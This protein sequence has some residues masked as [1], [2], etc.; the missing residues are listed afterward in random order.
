MEPLSKAIALN[1]RDPNLSSYASGLATSHILQRDYKKAASWARV[2]MRQPSSHFIA[3]MHL[4]AALALLGDRQGA[5]KARTKLLVLKPDFSLD[6]VIRNWP[7]KQ[8]SDTAL[9][10]R[11]LRSAG[12]LN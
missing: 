6:Y 10:L 12:I 7:F 4:V 8:A 2:A 9:F 1:P 5:Q 11:G 3:Q